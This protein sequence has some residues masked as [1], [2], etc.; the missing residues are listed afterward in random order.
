MALLVIDLL[1]GTP[2]LWA[3][4]NTG[5][6]EG[7]GGADSAGGPQSGGGGDGAGGEYGGGWKGD[8]LSLIKVVWCLLSVF[9]L[10]SLFFKPKD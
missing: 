3:N 8:L 4:S 1:A 6:G 2:S 9:Y 7:E 5:R 10:F